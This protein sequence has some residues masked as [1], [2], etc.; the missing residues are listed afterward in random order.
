MCV[1]QQTDE[2]ATWLK[3]LRDREARDRITA[4]LLRV[5]AGLPGDNKSVGGGVSELRINYGPG[6]RLYFT[7]RGA[8]IIVLLCGGDKDS[9]TRD[10][11]KAKTL[12][13]Q[14]D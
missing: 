14:L 8:E 11:T 4:Q 3:G 12:A 9:Q 1:V 6:Y 5:K 10:I 2:F 7:R 13:A